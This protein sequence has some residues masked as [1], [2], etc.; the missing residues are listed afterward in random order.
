M[1]LLRSTSMMAT[2]EHGHPKHHEYHEQH[3]NP[4]LASLFMACR[5]VC[6]G[7]GANRYCGIRTRSSERKTAE[8]F[9]AQGE[10]ALGRFAL[11]A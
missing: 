8:S 11:A 1:A 5:T 7:L 4:D 10:L 3:E 9:V 2:P 6:T